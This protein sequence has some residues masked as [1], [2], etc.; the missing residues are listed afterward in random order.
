MEHFQGSVMERPQSRLGGHVR[1]LSLHIKRGTVGVCGRC[2]IG[3]PERFGWIAASIGPRGWERAT[4]RR[5][6]RTLTWRAS[7]HVGRSIPAVPVE[8]G[9]VRVPSKGAELF[10]R[11]PGRAFAPHI[12]RLTYGEP[13]PGAL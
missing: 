11:H 9:R 6:D 1:S 5:L 10:A 3:H 7:G 13:L 12:H 4:H 2:P 8:A